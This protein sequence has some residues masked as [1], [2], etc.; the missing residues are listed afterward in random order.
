MN[1]YE[2][3]L[4][5]Y[6]SSEATIRQLAIGLNQ[7]ARK[8]VERFKE[9]RAQL[10]IDVE[11]A[12][13]QRLGWKLI[14]LALM[15]RGL[16]RIEW[17]YSRRV[18]KR[19]WPRRLRGRLSRDHRYPDS[20]LARFSTKEEMPLIISYE[21]EFSSLRATWAALAKTQ[22]SLGASKAAFSKVVVRQPKQMKP[23]LVGR[24]T[25]SSRQIQREDPNV[26]LKPKP[27]T[28]Y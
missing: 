3:T 9:E 5:F 12:T 11:S 24:T 23:L 7:A 25:R 6:D 20:M 2:A 14:P 22:R 13:Q 18:G 21:E 26:V 17:T 4:Q 1:Q 8:L 15:A 28:T 27:E 19:V 16:P 10:V